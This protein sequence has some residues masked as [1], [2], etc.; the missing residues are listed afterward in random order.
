MLNQIRLLRQLL[1]Y[2]EDRYPQ[3]IP[4]GYEEEYGFY[5]EY[6]RLMNKHVRQD[7]LSRRAGKKYERAGCAASCARGPR[8]TVTSIELAQVNVN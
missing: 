4:E 5:P 2:G 6:I 8:Q 7:V 1:E 3:P